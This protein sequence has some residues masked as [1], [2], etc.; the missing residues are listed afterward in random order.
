[1]YTGGLWLILGKSKLNQLNIFKSTLLTLLLGLAVLPLCSQSDS[2]V[3]VLVMEIRDVI[4]PRMNRYVELALQEARDIDADLVIID[5]D[6][7]GGALNDAD[8]ISTAVLEFEKPIA[9]LEAKLEDM[10]QLAATNDVDVT[11]AIASCTE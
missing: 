7:P 1:M 8:D 11:E 4:D 6:T 10:R 9:E 2:T 3:Q 5:M